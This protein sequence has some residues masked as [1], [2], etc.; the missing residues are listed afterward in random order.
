MHLLEPTKPAHT[1]PIQSSIFIVRPG[2]QNMSMKSLYEGLLIE[3][4]VSVPK[5][6]NLI[7]GEKKCFLRN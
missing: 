4:G 2:L 3:S 1:L 5:Q 6:N 7:I